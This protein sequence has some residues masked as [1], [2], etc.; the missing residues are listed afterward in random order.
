MKSTSRLAGVI[1]ASCALFFAGNSIARAQDP[2]PRE[3]HQLSFKIGAF[4]PTQGV[5]RNDSG[6]PFVAL[7]VEYDPN[8]RFKLFGGGRVVLGGDI[9]YR[10][11]AGRKYLIVPITVKTLWNLTNA[12]SRF[13][14]YGGIGAGLYFINTGF[15]GGTTQLGAKFIA[16]LDITEKV[17]AE[18]NYDY[19][20]GFSDNLGRGVRADGITF[21]LG[22]R[23]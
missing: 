9:Y 4:T 20:G 7:G 17:F 21:W 13:H 14:L 5:L 11:S 22:I 16:G 23:R 15:V 1:G 8:L 2:E 18:I 19:I 10:T 6:T 3:T 12:E